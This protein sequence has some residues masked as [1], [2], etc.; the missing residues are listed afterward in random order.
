M[1]AARYARVSSEHQAD[2][3][4]IPNQLERT[5]AYIEAQ[6]WELAATFTEPGES[7]ENLDRP[8][9]AQARAALQRGEY[10]VLAVY[11]LD[12]LTRD[13]DDLF[14]LRREFGAR[15]ARIVAVQ[16]GMDV[17]TANVDDLL[18]VLFR[19]YIGHKERETIR[20]RTMEGKERTAAAGKWPGG[21]L[22]LGYRRDP[23]TKRLVIHEPGAAVVRQ[24]FGW[25]CDAGL[26][27]RV[28]AERLDALG[29]PTPQ[30]ADHWGAS[31]VC[32]LVK[33]EVYTGRYTYRRRSENPII[34]DC[35]PIIDRATFE[36]ARAALARNRRN[37]A[38]PKFRYLLRGLIRCECGAAYCGK[39]PRKGD[40]TW[41]ARYCCLAQQDYRRHRRAYRCEG[42]P[43][44]AAEIESVVWTDIEQFVMQPDLVVA[45]LT[46]GRA[47][48]ED[49]VSQELAQTDQ[50][51]AGKRR[52]L[53]RYLRLYGREGMPVEELERVVTETKG[54]I[55]ALETYRRQLAD[56]QRQADL[57][58]AQ[59]G[60]IIEALAALQDKMT[61][62]LAWEDK[63]ALV[64]MLV[65]GIVVQTRT[66]ESGERYALAQVRYCFE[67]PQANMA[68]PAELVPLFQNV[69]PVAAS[70]NLSSWARIHAD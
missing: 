36:R 70:S 65:K 22:P 50:A 39:T 68:I 38:Q 30:G 67:R 29:I 56:Q 4:S 58:E 16:D 12:R 27:A 24:V 66:D 6:G 53:E 5:A 23:E 51:L 35:P 37:T 47:K 52:E 44:L 1:R 9:M 54:H 18:A 49:T 8:A 61:G 64:E 45:Q 26:S 43:I 11:T 40:R 28:I 20:R 33:N 63:R 2:N 10:D 69:E 7:G 59:M 19:G 46:Q 62:G 55:A 60:R 42:L 14:L 3:T 15:G 17:T 57:W 13:I 31:T 21:Y 41:P 25:L 32:V 34:I 48:A